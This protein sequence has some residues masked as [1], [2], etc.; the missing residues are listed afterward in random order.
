[1]CGALDTFN[2][3]KRQDHWLEAWR[4]ASLGSCV[5]VDDIA[6]FHSFNLAFVPPVADGL[7][8]SNLSVLQ[9]A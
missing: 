8:Q 7:R 3:K 2:L 4:Y 5:F 9:C 6:S 1:M